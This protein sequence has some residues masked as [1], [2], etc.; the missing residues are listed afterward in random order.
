MPAP[1]AKRMAR[2]AVIRMF[3][4]ASVEEMLPPL[5]PVEMSL[6]P[7]FNGDDD[8]ALPPLEPA[9]EPL[10]ATT[11]ERPANAHPVTRREPGFGSG[12]E[13]TERFAIHSDPG[14]HTPM[15]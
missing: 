5:E 15:Q 3:P 10:P 4:R 11:M 6:P 14:S 9:E 1:E 8:G 7:A 2:E 12:T 13:N